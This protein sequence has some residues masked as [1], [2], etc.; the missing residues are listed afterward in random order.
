MATSYFRLSAK[1]NSATG[2]HEILVRFT[3]GKKADLFAK[4]SLFFDE[5]YSQYWTD[6]KETP[7]NIPSKP[8]NLDKNTE[9]GKQKLAAIDYLNEKA[10]KLQNIRS[11]IE[12]SFVDAGAGKTPLS[13]KW[14][15]KNLDEFN[16]IAENTEAEQKPKTFLEVLSF[17]INSE[18]KKIS[19]G[20]RA[21][22]K[23]LLRLLKRYEIMNDTT[24][25]FDALTPDY[26]RA[27]QKYMRDEYKL[28]KSPTKRTKK[29]LEIAPD[30]RIS[31]PRG[32]NTIVI[33][34]KKLRAFV[35]W[36]NG[37]D[38]DYKLDEPYTNNNPFDSFS[39]G[40]EQ[41]GTPYYLTVEERNKLFQAQLPERLAR[42][43]DIFVFQCLTGCRVGD[44][45]AMT[46]ANIIDGAI[47]YVPQKTQNKRSRTVVVPL[48]DKA[49]EIL[50]RYKDC[51]NRLF[52]FVAQQQY[53]IDIKEMLKLAGIDRVVTVRNSLTGKIEQRPI[54]E[55][56]SS[57]MARRT[58][59]GNLYKIWKDPDLIGSMSGHIEGSRAFARYRDIDRDTKKEVVKSIE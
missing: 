13:S 27:I 2:E 56:A 54:Y 38:K 55:V 29:A 46:K 47:E 21:H 43:R 57:H 8:R 24:L 6:N 22:Y 26:I 12:H 42:Q 45:W 16:G 28:F 5:K 37:L 49:T 10:G 51:G 44:L 3:H 4:T 58:F 1:S 11:H 53:N 36:A 59:I 39:I 48:N 34:T 50:E 32:E 40:A 20:N 35:R 15:Q 25:S 52:P 17:Y 31:K 33:L 30:S 14:L 19:E 41:Y 18:D 7:I 9:E 23:S